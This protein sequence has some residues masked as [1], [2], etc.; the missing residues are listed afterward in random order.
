MSTGQAIRSSGRTVQ[1]LVLS[2]QLF[3][4]VSQLLVLVS[5]LRQLS[6]LLSRLTL[7][8]LHQD[9]H[10]LHLVLEFQV[11]ALQHRTPLL[12]LLCVRRRLLQIHD[13][14]LD[15]RL[16][17]RLLLLEVRTL[18]QQRLQLLL[19]LCDLGL[20]LAS[21]CG[22][23]SVSLPLAT[24]A[25]HS[26][27]LL[28]LLMV[29][30]DLHFVLGSPSCCLAVRLRQLALQVDARLVLLLQLH[31]QGLDLHLQGVRV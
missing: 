4:D 19:V 16:Q 22:N 28:D 21:E 2:R 10:L 17:A 12:Q 24:L 8:V 5:Q 14:H 18:G 3:L 6:C 1:L 23:E 30:L 11:R 9:C 27:Q 25:R 29:R 7:R 13:Q 26:P 15:L 31:L 20:Q